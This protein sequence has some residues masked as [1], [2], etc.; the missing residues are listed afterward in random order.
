MLRVPRLL[1]TLLLIVSSFAQ[2]LSASASDVRIHR[3]MTYNVRNGMGIDDSVSVRRVAD[4]ILRQTPE[5]VAVQELDSV[6]GRSK[7][8]YVLGELAEMTGMYP[9]YAPAIDYDGGRYGIGVLCAVEPLSVRRYALPGEEEARAMIVVEMPDYMLGCTH[10]SL[11]EA[12][13]MRSLDII[14]RV[15]ADVEKPFFIAGDF[16]AHPDSEFIRA[17][18]ADFTPLTDLSV[19]TFPADKP[20]ETID[21]IMLYTPWLSDDVRAASMVIDEPS[22]SDHRPV[23]TA[24]TLPGNLPPTSKFTTN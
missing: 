24:V 16:N 23:V 8:Q 6:T 1:L 17:M 19:P 5:I 10:L 9:C 4:V 18:L 7:G 11:T 14:R 21:Y 20:E 12:D 3:L 2:A 22:A 15:A 13:R